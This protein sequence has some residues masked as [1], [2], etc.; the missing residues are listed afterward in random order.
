[1]VVAKSLEIKIPKIGIVSAVEKVNHKIV[2][3]TDAEILMQKFHELPNP[4]FLMEGPFAIDNLVSQASVEHKQI[5]SNVAGV[6]DVLLFPDLV[7]G[8]VFYKTSV[9]LAN[10]K[11]AGLI[12]GADVPIILTSRADSAESKVNSILLGT[13]VALCN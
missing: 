3:T 1:L 7:S 5:H 4:S 13:L 8:N 2:S 9:F 11:V 10:A 12:I 6:V